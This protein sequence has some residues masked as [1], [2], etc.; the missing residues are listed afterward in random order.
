MTHFCQYECKS[1]A[2]YEY[3][4]KNMSD[5]CT[6]AILE[7]YDKTVIFLYTSHAEL[8]YFTARSHRRVRWGLLKG[9]R[10]SLLRLEAIVELEKVT[11]KRSAAVARVGQLSQQTQSRSEF[12]TD[13]LVPLPILWFPVDF[14]WRGSIKEKSRKNDKKRLV[15]WGLLL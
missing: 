15:L 5:S 3:T 8:K 1:W 10:R 9:S 13:A 2:L 12:S 11:E 7:I 4:G 14:G 6:R